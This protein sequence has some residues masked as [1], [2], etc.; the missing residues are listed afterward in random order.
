MLGK[1]KKICLT[2]D[3][4]GGGG[5]GGGGVVEPITF[6]MHGVFM[7][8]FTSIISQKPDNILFY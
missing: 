3:I 2:L 5:G 7:C 1:L 8:I 6:G 4:G